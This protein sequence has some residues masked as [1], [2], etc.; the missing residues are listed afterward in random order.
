MMFCISVSLK[1][2]QHNYIA[3]VRLYVPATVNKVLLR[4]VAVLPHSSSA[5]LNPSSSSLY[6]RLLRMGCYFF[7]TGGSDCNAL[8]D[9]VT[10]IILRKD[11][12]ALYY[13][14]LCY[15]LYVMYFGNALIL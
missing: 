3:Y 12:N 13:I 6:L 7:E 5:D 2:N 14:A 8:P 9:P 10:V 4:K 11:S 1:F 15:C